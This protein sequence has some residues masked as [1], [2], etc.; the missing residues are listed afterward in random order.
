MA[1]GMDE[2]LTTEELMDLRII[3]IRFTSDKEAHKK[4]PRLESRAPKL[5]DKVDRMYKYKQKGNED[6]S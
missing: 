6:Q 2:E 3:L 5:L 4:I 1:A